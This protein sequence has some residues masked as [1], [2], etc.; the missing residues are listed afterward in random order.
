MAFFCC[1]AA[2]QVV[3]AQKTI[4]EDP[5]ARFH[6]EGNQAFSDA[7]L[8]K[9]LIADPTFLLATHP[10]GSSDE[11]EGVIRNGLVYGYRRKG[12]PSPIISVTSQADPPL[13]TIRIDEGARMLC[14]K[15]RIQGG[16]TLDPERLIERLTKRF[17]KP[18][19]FPAFVEAGGEIR[20][21]W[22]N[23]KGKTVPLVDPVWEPGTPVSLDTETELHAAVVRGIADLGY[24]SAIVFT[25]VELNEET[26]SASL[27]IEIAEEGSKDKAESIECIGYQVNTPEQIAQA[28][29]WHPND[30]I[31]RSKIEEWTKQLWL[32]GRFSDQSVRFLRNKE[33]SGYLVVKVTE[34]PK[35]P[36]LGQSLSES[37]EVF[38]RAG[39]WIGGSQE[40]HD[41]LVFTF[42]DDHRRLRWIQSSKGS[43]LQYFSS[44]EPNESIP[45]WS[46]LFDDEQLVLDHQANPL[47]WSAGIAGADFHVHAQT[48]I[49][50]DGKSEDGF[51]RLNFTGNWKTGRNEG[52]SLFQHAFAVSPADWLAFAYKPGLEQKIVDGVLI[53]EHPKQRCRIDVATGRVLQWD[54][55]R[56][57]VYFQK[58]LYEKERTVLLDAV[59][60]KQNA[61]QAKHP[62]TSLAQFLCAA[63]IWNDIHEAIRDGEPV[64]EEASDAQRRAVQKLLAAGLLEPLDLWIG[65][66]EQGRGEERFF[67]PSNDLG[68]KSPFGMGIQLVARASLEY[69]PQIFPE[70]EW[71]LK[72]LRESALVGLGKPRYFKPVLKG[73]LE[74]PKIG[75]LCL[76][77]VAGLLAHI[78]SNLASQLARQAL[79]RVDQEHFASDLTGLLAG[80]G[81]NWF[82]EMLSALEGLEEEEWDAL[83]S[84]VL[85]NFPRGQALLQRIREQ[86]IKQDSH[87]DKA[88]YQVI[89]PDLRSALQG[90]VKPT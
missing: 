10:L 4:P 72:V 59:A 66:Q 83:S 73:L 54:S 9:A 25:R 77:S 29:G 71:P 53:A 44:S 48:G 19:T 26:H 30:E 80:P 12:F 38:R 40:R 49:L 34:V 60:E 39:N 69:G 70:G 79:L 18:N 7:A 21:R 15:I 14:G 1:C 36:S 84:G 6:F 45:R 75:P 61:Y 47:H 42:V 8:R 68:P 22:V 17:P 35:M 87:I 3:N 76:G 13:T 88:I 46:I 20:Q 2:S 67:V 63:P 89:E 64:V 57:G 33:G 11:L 37:A 90:M 55:D 16:V 86:L 65:K 81:G 5:W 51:A 27:V 43:L 50:A 56:G 24:S 31:D 41:D 82:K 85:K 62:L 58:G 28:I 32:S 52:Q 23:E 78:D 74:D